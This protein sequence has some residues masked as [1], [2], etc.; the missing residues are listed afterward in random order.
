MSYPCPTNAAADDDQED[1]SPGGRAASVLVYEETE[2]HSWYLNQND[3]K[4]LVEARGGTWRE[5]INVRATR[6]IY[7]P[8]AALL[9]P[10]V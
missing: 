10:R 9:P 2:T 5:A 8:A 4:P 1:D 6:R 7:A 3:L